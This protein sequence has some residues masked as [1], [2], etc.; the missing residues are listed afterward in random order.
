MRWLGVCGLTVV[1]IGGCGGDV[2]DAPSTVTATEA[3]ESCHVLCD[4][5]SSPAC[6]RQNDDELAACRR[7]CDGIAANL[8]TECRAPFAEFYSCA[9]RLGGCSG[10]V[11]N[12]ECLDA[13]DRLGACEG[14]RKVGDRRECD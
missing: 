7:S 6:P 2:D 1:A 13:L 9:S 11:V 12:D 5:Q 10:S 3:A 14:C 8:K 4:K